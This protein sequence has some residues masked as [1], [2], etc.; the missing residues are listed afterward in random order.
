M[1][2]HE[3]LAM[4]TALKRAGMRAVY[5]DILAD[6]LKRRHPV[7]QIIGALLKAEIADKLALRLALEVDAAGVVDDAIENGVR[8]G[9]FSDRLRPELRGDL[10]GD[11]GGPPLVALLDDLHRLAP[12]FD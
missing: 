10:T 5:D 4:M 1:E 11:E 7:Q 2:R 6:G 12:V 9:W 3:V 8:D